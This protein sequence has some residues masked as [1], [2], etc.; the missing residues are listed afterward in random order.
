MADF[1]FNVVGSGLMTGVA[2]GLLTLFSITRKTVVGSM[3][4]MIVGMLFILPLVMFT[5][6]GQMTGNDYTSRFV[7]GMI[8]MFVGVFIV[9]IVP[10]IYH[11][12]NKAK[13]KVK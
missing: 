10:E 12:R 13:S 2:A 7:F 3:C 11:R 5:M 4:S 6:H 1:L 9:A 8:S